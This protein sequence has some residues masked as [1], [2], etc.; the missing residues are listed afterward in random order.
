MD[1]LNSAVQALTAELARDP[2]VIEFKRLTALISED[3]YLQK[4][5]KRLKE[6]QQLLTQNVSKKEVHQQYKEEYIILKNDVESHPY[7]INFN[8]LKAEIEALLYSLKK[9]IE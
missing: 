7:I 2:R 8:T 9:V 3:P 6:L 5:E 4:A 1:K